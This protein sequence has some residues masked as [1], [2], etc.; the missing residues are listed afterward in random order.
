MKNAG[1]PAA[2]SSPTTKKMGS[3][4]SA[5][6]PIIKPTP[7]IE[8]KE[9]TLPDPVE[10]KASKPVK[11]IASKW[12]ER[13]QNVESSVEPQPAI[14]AVRQESEHLLRI[15]QLEK[16][17]NEETERHKK[18]IEVITQEKHI[19]E[20]QA[21]TAHE[22]QESLEKDISSLRLANLKANDKIKSVESALAT[23]NETIKSLRVEISTEQTARAAVSQS[24]QSNLQSA[25]LRAEIAEK[26]KQSAEEKLAFLQNDSS[27]L[28][29]TWQ[30]KLD[31]ISFQK[32]AIEAQLR[33]EQEK[34]ASVDEERANDKATIERLKHQIDEF[35]IQSANAA[36]TFGNLEKD[37]SALVAAHKVDVQLLKDEKTAFI[38]ENAKLKE[39][40]SSLQEQLD[41]LNNEVRTLV[42]DIEAKGK[43]SAELQAE[44][45]ALRNEADRTRKSSEVAISALEVEVR[46]KQNTVS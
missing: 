14:P 24:L 3:S 39:E 21:K 25:L 17:L 26:E 31:E 38:A 9:S 11:K 40:V 18:E 32:N 2:K 37:F 28:S 20:M 5:D 16:E 42:I 10:D 41:R 7:P 4:D 45:E 22:K 35:E 27:D 1:P 29:N 34:W 8:S 43:V 30:Q 15:S 46:S 44:N 36:E 12:T 6:E 19:S 33:I 23:A 13:N